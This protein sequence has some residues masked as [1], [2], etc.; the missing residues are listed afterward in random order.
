MTKEKVEKFDPYTHLRRVTEYFIVDDKVVGERTL[1]K[2]R[3][4]GEHSWFNI[5]EGDDVFH[6][7]SKLNY[8][9]NYSN[10]HMRS[11]VK[12][13]LDELKNEEDDDD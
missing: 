13:Q 12:E 11:G 8:L 10:V 5:P 1:L 9:N 6:Q 4:P 2:C 3:T 7:L